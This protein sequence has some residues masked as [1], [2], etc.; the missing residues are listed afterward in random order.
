MGRHTPAT[1]DLIDRMAALQMD[2]S[3]YFRDVRGTI[4]DRE[5]NL[6]RDTTCI[7]CDVMRLDEARK[8]VISILDTFR[9]D[10]PQR[11]RSKRELQKHI[12]WEYDQIQH[13]FAP[14]PELAPTG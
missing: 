9:T 6:L 11:Q 2:L 4:S 13:G 7:K 5:Q 12:A 1:V 8:D 14:A 10:L 3:R